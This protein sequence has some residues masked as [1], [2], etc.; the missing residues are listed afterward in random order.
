MQVVRQIYQENS[1]L[2]IAHVHR[3]EVGSE[4]QLAVSN[5]LNESTL[6]AARKD[7]ATQMEHWSMPRSKSLVKRCRNLLHSVQCRSER[8]MLICGQETWIVYHPQ[9]L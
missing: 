3:G 6:C 5:D 2:M 1:W 8:P 7:Q 9:S 4:P